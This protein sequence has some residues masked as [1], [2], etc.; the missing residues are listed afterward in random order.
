MDFKL[1]LSKQTD[2]RLD[3]GRQVL[4]PGHPIAQGNGHGDDPSA[5][6]NPRNHLLDEMRRRLLG[7]LP[8]HE[9]QNPRRLQLKA[10]NILCGQVSQPSRTK[11]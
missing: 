6:G 7:R 3:R 4:G 2:D 5:G 10:S 8:A 1:K 9:G 11:P